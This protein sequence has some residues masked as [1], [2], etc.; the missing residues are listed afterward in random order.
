MAFRLTRRYTWAVTELPVR[1]SCG[2]VTGTLRGVGV[3]PGVRIIC[4]CDDCQAFARYL[5]RSDILDRFGGTDIY[6]TAPAL[7]ELSAGVDQLRC[8]RLTSRGLMRWY[9][10]CCRTPVGNTLASP[11]VP[12]VGVQRVLTDHS[13]SGKS[14]DATM[15]APSFIQTKFA[16]APIPKDY[17]TRSALSAIGRTAWAIA[18]NALAGRARP[19]PFFDASGK[20]VA[21][22]L[23]LAVS[24]RRALY[25]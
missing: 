16:R 24:E 7:L 5:G 6:Q 18:N 13:G 11:A 4:T 1:C 10:D 8:L 9:T 15:G 23:V 22:P 3:T 19:S 20:P 14:R 12:F 2:S 25:G 21:K 17:V